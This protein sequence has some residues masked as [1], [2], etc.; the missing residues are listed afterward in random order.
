MMVPDVL[1]DV[2]GLAA[3]PTTCQTDPSK[4]AGIGSWRQVLAAGSET[5]DGPTRQRRANVPTP[6]SRSPGDQRTAKTIEPTSMKTEA[7]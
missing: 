6:R 1:L 5:F 7:E 2:V 3:G 4:K